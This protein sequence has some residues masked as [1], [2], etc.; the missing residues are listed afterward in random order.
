M[1]S[2]SLKNA[3]RFVQQADLP[4]VSR[5]RSKAVVDTIPLSFDAEKNEA[6]VVGSD[7]ISFVSG[8]T[9]ARREPI[10]NSSLLTQLVTK[11]KVVATIEIY[12]WYKNYFDVL[13]N[14]GWVVQQKD[15]AEFHQE[16]QNFEAH[17]AVLAVATT[18]LGAAPTALALVKTTPD[19][20]HSMSADKPWITVFNRE[21]HSARTDHFQIT[22]AEQDEAGQ[23]FVTLMAFG[24]EASSSITQVLFFKLQQNEATQRHC[25][26]KVMITTVVPDDLNADLKVIQCSIR[27]TT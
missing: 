19:A 3:R 20:L 18:L 12:T 11:R 24:L 21:S 26:G 13:A 23:F 4:E 14:I 7:A 16:S 9:A 22:L 10:V 17:Q 27:A 8:V 5:I 2:T 25:L 6:A 1:T 15:F